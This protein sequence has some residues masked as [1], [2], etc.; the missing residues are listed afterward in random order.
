M[1][2]L[3]YRDVN[4][5]RKSSDRPISQSQREITGSKMQPVEAG[6]EDEA[7]AQADHPQSDFLSLLACSLLCSCSSLSYSVV[8][9]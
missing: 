8:R 3:R 1:E 9:F 7:G 5:D 2:P 6:D 4:R